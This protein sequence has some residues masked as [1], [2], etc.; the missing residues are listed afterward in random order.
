M[1]NNIKNKQNVFK[2]IVTLLNTFSGNNIRTTLIIDIKLLYY[3]QINVTL[4]PDTYFSIYIKL[5]YIL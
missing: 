1:L 2:S 5:N 4:Y 3:Y